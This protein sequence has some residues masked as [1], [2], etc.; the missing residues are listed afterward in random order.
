MPYNFIYNRKTGIIKIAAIDTKE[1]L[2]WRIEI[3]HMKLENVSQNF[4]SE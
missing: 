4:L 1:L 3:E 2:C